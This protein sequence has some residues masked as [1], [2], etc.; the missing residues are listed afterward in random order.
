VTD[1]VV[2]AP[3]PLPIDRATVVARA[4]DVL[5]LDP[6]DDDAPRV[7]IAADVAIDLASQQLDFDVADVPA[8]VGDA[9]TDAVV[10][11]TIEQYRRKDAPFGVTDSWSVDGAVLR[12]SSDV[13]RG[14]RAQ[15]GKYRSRRGVA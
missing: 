4:L 5:R 8:T 10:T 9:V 12:L 14:V 7:E 6:T 11:L 3:A 1:V 2:S 15:L 13:F